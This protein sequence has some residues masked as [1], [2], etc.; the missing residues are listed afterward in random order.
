MATEDKNKPLLLATTPSLGARLWIE[1]DDAGANDMVCLHIGNEGG[2]GTARYLATLP[3]RRTSA[4]RLESVLDLSRLR[5]SPSGDTNGLWQRHLRTP[6][7]TLPTP[8]TRRYTG[9]D[10]RAMSCDARWVLVLALFANAAATQPNNGSYTD[11]EVVGALEAFFLKQPQQPHLLRRGLVYL[12]AAD[13]PPASQP[14]SPVSAAK[15]APGEAEPAPQPVSLAFSFALA[16]CQYPAGLVDGT[17][18]AY[19]EGTAMPPGPADV[20]M[21]RLAARLDG[22]DDRQRPSLLVLTG[23]QIY[24]DATAGLFDPRAGRVP[25]PRSSIRDA[26]NWLRV[27]YQNWY[28]SVGAQAVLSRLITLMMLDD[29]EIDNNWEPLAEPA[30]PGAAERLNWLRDAG[31][32]AYQRYQRDLREGLLLPH[33]WHTRLHRGIAFFMADTRTER[34]ARHAAAADPCGPCIMSAHQTTELLAWIEAG[35]NEAL[36]R[37]AF[38]VSPAMLLPRRHSSRR[39]SPRSLPSLRSALHSDAWDGYPGSLHHLLVQ[40]WTIGRSNLVFL[41]GDEHLSCVVKATVTKLDVPGRAVTLHSVHSSGLYSPYPFA[42]AVPALFALPDDWEFD[43]PHAPGDRYRC[44]V[45]PC[46]LDALGTPWAPGDG[47]ALLALA[48]PAA[49]APQ[50]QPQPQTATA[51]AT[52]TMAGAAVA[53]AWQLDICFDR[54]ASWAERCAQAS[55]PGITTAACSLSLAPGPGRYQLPSA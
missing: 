20:S 36:A 23:D 14:V 17:P 11:D 18:Q 48:P 26:E 25:A 49:T 45:E 43:D 42:N 53:A 34:E 29:H 1:R 30:R 35:A 47:F 41:S 44:V 9:D 12:A 38:I 4:D 8:Y 50:P 27:P 37:P 16:S 7:K 13:Q 15:L 40:L 28:G 21:L 24:A 54:A 6:P 2:R 51:T 32:L 31:S 46:G 3:V 5:G 52:A 55:A 39:S 22:I 10:W 33:L 19:G